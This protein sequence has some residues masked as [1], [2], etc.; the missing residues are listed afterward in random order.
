V[1][2]IIPGIKPDHKC[3]E[4]LHK[5]LGLDRKFH[6]ILELKAGHF[7][8]PFGKPVLHDAVCIEILDHVDP[9]WID[10]LVETIK[11]DL[12]NESTDLVALYDELLNETT[13]IPLKFYG[14]SQA[15]KE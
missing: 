9:E 3:V 12:S 14:V 5:A 2:I 10:T 1:K 6:I 4:L 7:H 11:P 13:I 8:A 15:T